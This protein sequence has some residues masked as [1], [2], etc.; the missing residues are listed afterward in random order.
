MPP[1]PPAIFHNG[2]RRAKRLRAAKNFPSHDFVH[3][4]A[5]EDVVD[6]L[7]T[8]LKRFET[9][10]FYGPGAEHVRQALTEKADIGEAVTADDLPGADLLAAADNLPFEDESLDL[11]V[12]AMAMH[13]LNDPMPA[14]LETRRVLKPDGLFVAVLPGERSLF[15]LRIALQAAEA[16]LL[17]RVAPRVAPMMAV[18]DG[19]ALLQAA[20]FALPVADVAR[21]TVEYEYPAKLFQDLRG[22]GETSALLAGPKGAIRRD[23]L[24]KTIEKYLELYPAEAGGIRATVDLITLTG[25]KP[26]QSQP[27]PLKPGS[28]KASLRDAIMTSTER[29]EDPA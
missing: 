16:E 5:A 23:V 2:A 4:R 29:T 26:H 17:G 3:L 9:A 22:A 6:R 10:L 11:V 14:L 1:S 13:A 15:E 27:K 28:A 24:T 25:W 19:G 8:V 7:E 21:L 20:G 12:S 18:K